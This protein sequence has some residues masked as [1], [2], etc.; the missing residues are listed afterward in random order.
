MSANIRRPLAASLS[1]SSFLLTALA[2]VRLARRRP[3]FRGGRGGWRPGPRRHRGRR[4]GLRAAPHRH[5]PAGARSARRGGALRPPGGLR[6]AWPR[7]ARQ[8]GPMVPASRISAGHAVLFGRPV[9]RPGLRRPRAIAGAACSSRSRSGSAAAGSTSRQ[10]QARTGMDTARTTGIR[11]T[12]RNTS[13]TTR[14]ATAATG[15]INRGREAPPTAPR[16]AST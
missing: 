12:G 1:G 2:D 7:P 6:G 11:P 8:V 16:G 9:L 5:L 4:A 10:T 14:T 13:T 3:G 15:T